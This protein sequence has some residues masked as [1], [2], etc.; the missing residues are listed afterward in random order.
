MIEH[1]ASSLNEFV[2]RVSDVLDDWAASEAR[3]WFRGHC[4]AT[5][6]LKPWIYREVDL[7]ED[8]EDALRRDFMLR[9]VPYL[10][11]FAREPQTR[12]DWYFHMQHHGLPTRLLDWSESALVALYFA[13]RDHKNDGKAAAVWILDPW[14]MNEKFTR[15]SIIMDPENEAKAYLHEPYDSKGVLPRSPIAIRARHTSRRI[16]A[17][18]GAFTIHG[19]DNQGLEAYELNRALAKIVIP[20]AS[21]GAIRKS[22][23]T[24]GITEGVV[25]P[26]LPG[27]CREVLDYW[28]LTR[29]GSA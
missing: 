3:L 17:Q 25:F 1:T 27:I 24:A 19:S 28:R 26:E 6:T 10:E 21:V 7:L 5:W 11:G 13:I 20:C 8:F 12:W 4:D 16:A 22:L 18:R 2:A 15:E 23:R 14:R 29:Q 9:A